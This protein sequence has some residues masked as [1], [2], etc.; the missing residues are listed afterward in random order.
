M[1]NLKGRGIP[2][3]HS[4]TWWSML[5]A[6]PLFLLFACAGFASKEQACGHPLIAW[7]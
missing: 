5:P 6:L 3:R 7:P 2:L 4:Q 1:K